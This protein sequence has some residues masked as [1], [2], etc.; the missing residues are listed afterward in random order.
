[1][2]PCV[3]S[4][5]KQQQEEEELRRQEREVKL[6][7]SLG[8]QGVPTFGAEVATFTHCADAIHYRWMLVTPEVSVRSGGWIVG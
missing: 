6:F 7:A 4:Q 8:A 1:M 2:S 5:E 3:H